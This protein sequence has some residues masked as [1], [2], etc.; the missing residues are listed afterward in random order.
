MIAEGAIAL[1]WATAGMTF[2]DSAPALAA[3]LGKGGAANVVN[4]VCLTLLGGVGGVLAIL[5]VVVLPITSGDTAF[6]AARL[7]VSDF[8]GISQEK[9]VSRLGIAVPLFIIGIVLSQVDFQIIW[10][11][12]GWSNQ[13]LATVVLW[14]AAAYVVKRGANHWLLTIPATFMTATVIA[15][16]CV[17]PEGFTL[18]YATSVVIGCAAAAL[19]L[20]VFLLKGVKGN[21]FQAHTILELTPETR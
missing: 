19:S 4:E 6:R 12:F 16:I 1:I 20:G 5:G 8:T 9:P 11:Y 18:P 14:S 3:A 2:Y 21:W 7:L 17:A 10:R 13:T 15:Y